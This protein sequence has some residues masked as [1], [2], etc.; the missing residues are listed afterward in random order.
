MFLLF[1][2][3]S[4]F[5]TF[6]FWKLLTNL[7]I[8]IHL[9]VQCLTIVSPFKLVPVHSW[10]SVSL[11]GSTWLILLYSFFF[12]LFIIFFAF[13]LPFCKIK[14]TT[15]TWLYSAGKYESPAYIRLSLTPP[16]LLKTK[17]IKR[18]EW[19]MND[20]SSLYS[21]WVLQKCSVFVDYPFFGL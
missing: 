1:C 11:N 21:N 14:L 18:S 10:K 4:F 7:N 20:Y 9:K 16:I 13:Y 12:F 3:L 2:F 5:E 15:Y 6:V 19:L 17:F 8:L